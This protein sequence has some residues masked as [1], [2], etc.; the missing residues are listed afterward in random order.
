M[1]LKINSQSSGRGEGYLSLLTSVSFSGLS[2][3]QTPVILQ[4]RLEDLVSTTQ[5]CRQTFT[6]RHWNRCVEYIGLYSAVKLFLSFGASSFH[7]PN[8]NGHI[9]LMLSERTQNSKQTF[10]ELFFCFTEV[11]C[12]SDE[13]LMDEPHLSLMT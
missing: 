8:N 7:E 5:P 13:V 4:L 10:A 1:V 2:R 3:R 11:V 9:F 6:R 12:V